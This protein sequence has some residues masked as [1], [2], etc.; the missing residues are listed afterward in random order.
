MT[1][2]DVGPALREA[3]MGVHE[4]GHSIDLGD[5]T[6]SK[7]EATERGDGRWRAVAEDRTVVFNAR[8]FR[9]SRR[10][11]DRFRELFDVDRAPG[12]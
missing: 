2:D 5:V 12:G 3:M 1:G 7:P 8:R 10:F 4:P 11:E 9:D 6:L